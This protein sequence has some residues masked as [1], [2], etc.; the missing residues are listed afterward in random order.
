M[1]SGRRLIY[2]VGAS[3][4]LATMG[5]SAWAFTHVVSPGET[6]SEIAK[7]YISGSVYGSRGSLAKIV[8]LNPEIRDPNFIRVGQQVALAS[9]A[10]PVLADTSSMK[11]ALTRSPAQN[12]VAAPEPAPTSAPAVH[13]GPEFSR[14]DVSATLAQSRIAATDPTTG[15]KSV[16]GSSFSPGLALR[17]DQHWTSGSKSFLAAKLRKESFATTSTTHTLSGNKPL[18]YGFG[19]GA[20]VLALGKDGALDASIDLDHEAFVR[21][22]SVNVIT[23]DSVLVPKLQLAARFGLMESPVLQLSAELKGSY[24]APVKTDSYSTKSGYGAS[25]ALLWHHER[26]KYPLFGGLCFDY[27]NQNTSIS[28]QNYMS[29]GLQ[30]GFSFDVRDEG[31]ENP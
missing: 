5:V 12:E 30:F 31:G 8:A 15:G 10:A 17:W 25:A 24:L 27:L 23:V 1:K 19:F 9:E 18:L 28:K 16:L 7:R 22:S 14:F 21:A 2:Q 4:G 26:T 3:L 29:A 11:S 13:T 6:L 20:Q